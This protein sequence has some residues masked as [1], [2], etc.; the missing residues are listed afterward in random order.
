MSETCEV[1]LRGQV[2]QVMEFWIV[3]LT[4]DERHAHVGWRHCLSGNHIN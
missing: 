4:E 1:Y 2:P 3:H